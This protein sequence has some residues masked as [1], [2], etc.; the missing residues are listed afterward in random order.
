MSKS[1]KFLPNILLII[2]AV[3]I[4]LSR[5]PKELEVI[6]E[7]A[8]YQKAEAIPDKI[9][10]IAIDETTLNELGP[11]SEWDRALFAELINKLNANPEKKPRVIGIDVIFSGTNNSESDKALV[12]AVKNS[13]NV[14][15][16]SKLETDTRRIKTENGYVLQNYVKNETTAFEELNA[17]SF[18]GFTN[19]ILDDDGFVRKA[20]TTIL[21]DKKLYK[22][23]SYMVAESICDEEELVKLPNI[24]EIRYTGKP[25]DF[26]TIPMSKVLD[27]T[28][29]EGYFADS[30]V[31][32]GAHEEGM[33]DS[34]RVPIDRSTEMYGVECH[35]NAVWAFVN[36]K[37]IFPAPVWIE[38]IICAVIVGLLSILMRKSRVRINVIATVATIILYPLCAL[39]IFRL[40]EIRLSLLY[41]PIAVAVEFLV[42]LLIRYIAIQKERADEMQKMLFSMADCMAEAIE[43]RTPYNAN[44]T[45][46]VAKRSIEM[47][48][49]INKLHKERKSELHFSKKD[50]R[51]MYLAAMLHDI[52]KMDVPLEVM[53]KPTKLG[54]LEEPLRARLRIISLKLE[55]DALTGTVPKEKA[56]TQILQINEFLEKLDGFNCGRP[57]KDDEWKVID[58]MG[59]L[60]YTSQD[61]EEIPFLTEEELDDLHIKAG[62]LSDNERKIMQSHVVYTDKILSHMHFGKDYK[63]VR[64]MASNHHELLNAKGYPNGIGADKLDVMTRILTIMDIY[65]SLIADDRPYKKPKP[66]KVAFNI[67]DEEA[68]MGKID[69]ELLSVAKEIWLKEE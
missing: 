6:S 11:Y 22:S 9:K 33:L 47:L 28:V 54:R 27:G 60:K 68:E 3:C 66:V 42:F 7:D 63:D 37:Q 18:S 39:F 61:G 5:F 36:G 56:D 50:K 53:D 55:N 1:M 4:T 43:G 62:T 24:V 26:E 10:I 48:D 40:S 69:A 12:E 64:A 52:G 41:V 17:V 32:V 21:S 15:L 30:V 2:L 8:L 31:L 57:L 23:F 29:P 65:D 35:A 49:Y 45:K 58:K 44:H 14:V 38:A 25:D 46:N 51:Q 13:G 20:Y 19:I 67:L 59:E 34:Y 16:A